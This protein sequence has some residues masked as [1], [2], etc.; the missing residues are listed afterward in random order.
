MKKQSIVALVSGLFLLAGHS[1]AQQFNYASI[2]V[3]CSAAPPTQCQNGVARQTV[4]SGIN[5]AGDIVGSY[6]DGVGRQHGFLWSGW[7]F[8]TVVSG[9]QPTV[10]VSGGQLTTIDVPGDLAGVGGS[11]PTSAN[12]INPAGDIV[13][14]FAAPFIT[15]VSDLAPQDSPAYCPAAG[16]AACIKG[17][18]YR[19]GKFSAVLFPGHPG[20]VPQRITPDG[21]IYGCLHDFDLM[22]SMFGAAWTR[23]GNASLTANGGELADAADSEPMSMNNGA[24]PGGDVIVGLFNDMMSGQRHGFVVRDGVFQQYDVDNS[25]LTAIWDINPGQQFVGTY[26]DKSTGRR[27]G[28]LQLSDGSAPINVDFPPPAP[29]L[30]FPTIA[31]GINPDG[32]I[33]GQYSAGGRIHGFVAVPA[34]SD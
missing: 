21:D 4:P 24:T 9:G 6:L 31:F 16:S 15:G 20:A 34:T 30:F 5:P 29:K 11:L 13:G 32:V 3:P 7:L 25:S 22:G 10:V 12:G 2:D 28:F 1:F 23:L 33:V 27:H 17:F 8:T 19:H 14:N 18:L 26:V